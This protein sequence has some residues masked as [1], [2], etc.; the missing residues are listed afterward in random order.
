MADAECYQ[1]TV[2]DRAIILNTRAFYYQPW[3][4]S[5][6]DWTDL[7]CGFF[8]SLTDAANDDLTTGLAETIAQPTPPGMQTT[9]RYW[10]G[11]AGGAVAT[12]GPVFIGFTNSV[13]HFPDVLGDTV[14]ASSDAAVGTTNTKFW[15]TQT[16]TSGAQRF[17]MDTPISPEPPSWIITS[18]ISR[19]TR[20][21]W[22]PV[23]R[24]SWGF[25]C[26]AIT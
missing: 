13:N 21:R 6:P 12:G 15:L 2:D 11:V 20:R 14:L 10:L 22:R 4:V 23:T 25:N 5:G 24:C 9:D 26:Y 17:T 7:R 18:N 3:I 1:K 8:L 19:R 16:I